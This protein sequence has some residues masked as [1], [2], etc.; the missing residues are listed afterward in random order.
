[1]SA[2]PIGGANGS[3]IIC[4]VRAQ[5]PL[6]LALA[7]ALIS[8]GCGAEALT[9]PSKAFLRANPGPILH[10]LFRSTDRAEIDGEIELTAVASDGETR[11]ANLIYEWS[12][13]AGQFM[14]AGATVR[15]RAPKVAVPSRQVLTLRVL[16]RYTLIGSGRPRPAEN[17]I[18]AS[19]QVFVNDSPL[20]LKK[21]AFTFIDDF[22]HSDR[23][24]EYCV[25][26]FS[27]HC[28]GKID[29][30]GDVR[31]NREE[32]II[33][34]RAS[35]FAFRSMSFDTP[36]NSPA[37]ASFA[38]VR[39]NCHFVSTRKAT[40]LTEI[41]DGICRMTNVYEDYRWRL[42]ESRFD[43]PPGSATQFIF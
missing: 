2:S 4:D 10:A 5:R 29:E 33:D 17:R 37:Q 31:R 42:C 16:E 41:A 9:A 1:M 30:L 27:D 43:P 35:A 14:G 34:S 21:L 32:F 36:E 38:T 22:V 25:R 11:P 39:L 3:V 26:N 15:W 13:T 19:L 12:A 8:N 7:A 24:P 18:E 28:G 23:A 20:E 40:G 6:V